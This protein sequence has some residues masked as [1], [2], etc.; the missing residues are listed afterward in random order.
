MRKYLALVRVMV[1]AAICPWKVR[2]IAR[3]TSEM[4]AGA[5]AKMKSR[6][7]IVHHCTIVLSRFVNIKKGNNVVTFKG[8]QL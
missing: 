2:K 1:L 4:I 8:S 7:C 6:S 3:N 5:S